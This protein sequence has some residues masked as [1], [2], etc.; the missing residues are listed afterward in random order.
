LI[1][2]NSSR[3]SFLNHSIVGF[4]VPTA[5]QINVMDLPTVD[6]TKVSFSAPI[7]QGGTLKKEVY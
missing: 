7:I 2:N 5:G 6:S 1:S 4:G 3:S